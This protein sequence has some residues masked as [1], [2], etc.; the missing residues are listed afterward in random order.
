MPTN[1]DSK[2]PSTLEELRQF[3]LETLC[4]QDAL[5]PH[6]VQLLEQPIRREGSFAGLLWELRG[7]RRLRTIAIWACSERR[8]YFYN[9]AGARTK[10]V[11]LT[12][13]PKLAEQAA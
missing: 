13:S 12:S 4:A 7:P 9:S 6:Q 2:A 10:V 8:V 11:R 3:V 5:D 1:G